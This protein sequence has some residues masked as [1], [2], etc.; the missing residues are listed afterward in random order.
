MFAK[1]CFLPRVPSGRVSY[2]SALDAN[3]PALADVGATA[4]DASPATRKSTGRST[5]IFAM[6][7]A[8]SRVVGLVR[9]IAAAAIYGTRGP[10]AAFVVAFQVPNLLRSLVADAALSAAFVPAF[11]ELDEHGRHEEAGRLAGAFF[12]L[13]SLVLGLISFVAVVTAPWVMPLFA[14]SLPDNLQDDLVGLSQLMFP[15]VVLLGLTGLVMGILQAH[16]EFTAIAFVPVLWNVVIVAGLLV[17]TPMVS[18]GTKIYVYAIGILVGTIAQ[19]LY[20]LPSLRGKGPFPI[21]FGRGNPNVR[22]V[23]QLMLPVTIGLGLINFTLVINTWFAARVSEESVRAIDAAFR[24]YI[25]PQGIFSV[26]VSTVL[27][28]AIARLA[29]RNDIAGMRR[30]VTDGTRQIFFLLIP[31]TA[32]LALLATPVTRLIFEY[33]EFDGAATALTSGALVFFTLGLVFNGASLL[34]IRAFFSLKKPWIPTKIAVGTL[35]LNALLDA[36]LHGPLGTGGIP[37]ATSLASFAG[38]V[39]LAVALSR[40]LGGLDG[41]WLADGFVKTLVASV[42]LGAL[43]WPTWWLLDDAL[44]RSIPARIVSV[45]GAMVVGVLA[46]FSSARGLE[47][48]EL[49]MMARVMRSLR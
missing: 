38:F 37:L 31:A 49:R 22:R 3:G 17:V 8:V 6:W 11:T 28:P 43:A 2:T 35:V 26:A 48:P 29:A 10:I 45:G 30:T 18:E 4:D 42:W 13:I 27:F 33:G 46:Y 14:P 44:G 40:E 1:T 36:V 7:T 15:I 21:S 12:G 9:E 16:N 24:L 34:L 25:L 20:L 47:L 5:A 19:L 23:L 41:G 39:L 32:F